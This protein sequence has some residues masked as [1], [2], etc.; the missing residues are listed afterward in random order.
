[1]FVVHLNKWTWGDQLAISA[2]KSE[3][4]VSHVL[5]REA[6]NFGHGSSHTL[7]HVQTVMCVPR[8]KVLD[9]GVDG[10]FCRYPVH[11]S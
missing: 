2:A 3:L 4:Q 10:N 9:R 6:S 1:M 8:W 5:L 11:L 7:Q